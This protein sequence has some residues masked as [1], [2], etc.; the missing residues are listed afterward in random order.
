MALWWCNGLPLSIKGEVWDCLRDRRLGGR[1]VLCLGVE[2]SSSLLCSVLIQGRRWAL[3]LATLGC[4]LSGSLLI[5]SVCW[6]SSSVWISPCCS[7]LWCVCRA[8]SSCCYST[9][10]FYCVHIRV[11]EPVSLWAHC[12]CL[13]SCLE[14]YTSSNPCTNRLGS[15]Y[16]SQSNMHTDTAPSGTW[17]ITDPANISRRPT[18]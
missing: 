15:G 4:T 8:P 5:I 6:V 10:C 13:I 12:C 2:L 1:S 7:Y 3:L 17:P 14:Q 9:F 18:Y 11:R 16:R